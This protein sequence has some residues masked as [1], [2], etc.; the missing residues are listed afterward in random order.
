MLSNQ[1]YHE[2]IRKT[3]IAFGTLF[4]NIEIVSK[5]KQGNQLKQMRVPIAYGPTQKFLARLEERPILSGSG[6][7]KVGITLPRMSF[8]MIGIQY[9]SSRKISTLQTFNSVN[10]ESGKLVKNFMPVPYNISMQLNIL[11]KLNEDALQ[12][13]EQILPYFQ[14]N[15]TLTID[16]VETLG[17][18]RDIPIT[19]ESIS[20][21]DTY[22]EDFTTRRNIT[23]T[24]N[25]SCKTYLYGP[26][27]SATAGLIKKAQV[28]YYTDTS[29]LKTGSRQ[30]RYTVTPA[31]IRDYDS[32]NQATTA[33]VVDDVV[34]KFKVTV[35]GSLQTDMFI[36]IDD[37]VMKIKQIEQ[38]S[39]TVLRG[40]FNSNTS[41]HD[42]G[43]VIN[44]IT[45]VDDNLIDIDD[46]FGFSETIEEFADGKYYSTTKG[47]DV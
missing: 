2:I 21:D 36:Q 22:E 45:P 20:F 37:E 14:P 13:L 7:A 39:I 47:V 1:F 8:E 10:K 38:D 11:T 42:I 12:I 6:P 19:L 40:Q 30:L 33:Q 43:T 16:L 5:D 18:K 25:F 35:T 15:F 28:D 3:I 4:N 9:D 31:A 46:D 44:T 41:P 26:S 17:E 32:D 34:T 27:A 23:Y 24:L 29:N